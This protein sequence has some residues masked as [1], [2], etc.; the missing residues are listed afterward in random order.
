MLPPRQLAAAAMFYALY[1]RYA[2]AAYDYYFRLPAKSALICLL[3]TLLR[4]HAAADAASDAI[5]AFAAAFI[6]AA[7][8]DC[9]C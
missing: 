7:I 4:R 6:A 2:A 8:D 1:L 5:Y 9:R 3:I